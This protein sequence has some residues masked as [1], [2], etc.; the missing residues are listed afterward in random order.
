MKKA[1]NQ[2]RSGQLGQNAAFAVTL[3]WSC[4]VQALCRG[5][6]PHHS[7]HAS[8]RCRESDEDLISIF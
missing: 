2:S 6:G 7:L 3:L 8:A 1:I 4:V 5:D